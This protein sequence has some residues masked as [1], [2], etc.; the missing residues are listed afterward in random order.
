VNTSPIL[1]CSTARLARSL[2]N[3]HARKLAASQ[4]QWQPLLTFT[5][6][7]WLEEWIE[8]A[9]LCGDIA[10]DDMPRGM[11]SNAQE[12]L[13]WEQAIDSTLKDLDSEPLFDKAG[14]AAAAQEANRLLIEWNLSLDTDDLAE[15]TRQFLIWRQRF[16]SLCKQGGWLE[17]VRYFS[18]QLQCLESGSGEVP[19]NISLAGFDRLSPLQQ[20]LIDV[21]CARGSEV[22][23]HMLG[24]AQA[25]AASHV[26][27]SDQE[28]ECRAAIEWARQLLDCNPAVRLAIVVPEL[29]ALRDT[30]AALLD[31]AFHPDCV[32]PMLAQAARRYDFSLG[33]PLSSQPIIATGLN[34]L[35]FG[36]QRQAIP[37]AEISELL[38]NP[39]W[40][41]AFSEADARA[42]LDASMRERLPLTL[43]PQ[44]FQHFVQKSLNGERP[45]LLVALSQNLQDL[46]K[47][48]Q[49]QRARQLP[50]AWAAVFRDML[51]E[52]HWPGER[53]LSS[54]EYQ[55][56]QSFEKSLQSLS[57][58]DPLLGSTHATEA[59]KRLAQLCKE[60]IF[61]P[62]A[63]DLPQL[64]VLG[65]LEAAAEPLDAM[66]VMGMND[67]VWPPAPSPN[68]LLPAQLQR[69]VG[70]PNADSRVQM[71][72]AEAIQ[73]RLLCSASKVVFSSAQKDGERL[74]RISPLLHD[75]APAED[76]YPQFAT[77]AET[78]AVDAAK[79]LH[80][81]DDAR[82]PEI[83]EGEH[84]SGGTGLLK[85]QAICPAWAFY[86][87]RL[88]A[89]ALKVPVN[90][91]DAM[92]R[93]T[94]VHA[95]LECFWADRRLSEVQAMP[96]QLLDA[97]VMEAADQALAVF[98]E[99]RDASLS[100]PFITLERERLC[101]LVL[102]WLREVEMRRS[103]DFAVTAREQ[104]AQITIEGISIRLVLDRIDTLDDGSLV[105]L[106][107]KTGR[108]N[109]Y[110]NWAD[111]RITEPQLPIYAA[112]VLTDSDVAAVCFAQVRIDGNGFLGICCD[113]DVVPGATALTDSKGRKLFPEADFP[114]WSSLLMHWRYSI[115]NIARE[116]KSGE[117]A[118]RF[119][120]EKQLA[121]CEVLPLLR[122][123][124]RWLQYERPELTEKMHG[125]LPAGG[126][127]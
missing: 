25:Q 80:F 120:D 110:R 55:A 61:Q 105:L 74:L 109:N 58:L 63:V 62:E 123:P 84:V 78:L 108:Q 65:M 121:Y 24:F 47:L 71:E 99:K 13:L 57:E 43:T 52:T 7:V 86:Q 124:E 20:R 125:Q 32:T 104:E 95:V 113:A 4:Q 118:I 56:L 6:N 44:R 22:S 70:T 81:I 27:L 127:R 53:S 101:K 42:Q 21:L 76:D 45:L 9:L 16:Q 14:L 33:V 51:H 66:W 97:A 37:Q 29:S 98:N 75:V 102:A 119:V 12:R 73:R 117:A 116:L 69:A 28:A 60:Q 91:L 96:V 26:E 40:S 82:A 48:G 54:H 72:F 30:F 111:A 83:Q 46:L 67:H 39:Y 77:L 88:H 93:G 59:I 34:L 8:Q 31:E 89:R 107:Y 36:L 100:E 68:P 64:Q 23:T 87:Y 126:Q 122:L 10:P 15:E 79:H 3:L 106:D 85:A 1:L 5:L 115:E 94:L 2:R 49:S 19:A 35:R 38:L 112:F 92:E 11:L 103:M 17:P 90:G 18:W 50:S 41:A 114:D